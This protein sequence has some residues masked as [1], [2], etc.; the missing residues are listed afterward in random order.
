MVQ[1]CM[2]L[3][4]IISVIPSQNILIMLYLN[5]MSPPVQFRKCLL[6]GISADKMTNHDTTMESFM[7]MVL[8]TMNNEHIFT[9]MG[10]NGF[11]NV[12]E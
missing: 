10:K 11:I 8:E 7:T 5:Q 9:P 4:K 2:C 6:N 1:F 3:I 12:F